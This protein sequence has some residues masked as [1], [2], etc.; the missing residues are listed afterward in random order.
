MTRAGC[1]TDVYEP[2]NSKRFRFTLAFLDWYLFCW[3]FNYF[4][5]RRSTKSFVF[6]HLEIKNNL[7]EQK[8]KIVVITIT[9]SLTKRPHLKQDTTFKKKKKKWRPHFPSLYFFR[10]LSFIAIL[11][12]TFCEAFSESHHICFVVITNPYNSDEVF[13]KLDMALCFSSINIMF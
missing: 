4:L 3:Q 7:F 9:S 11:T 6:F 12:V 1:R 5:Y 8:K 13:A 2:V 10:Y